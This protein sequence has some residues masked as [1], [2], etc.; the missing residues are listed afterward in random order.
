MPKNQFLLL[1]IFQNTE[2]AQLC[3]IADKKA[4]TKVTQSLHCTAELAHL[5]K[6]AS[7]L[8]LRAED[9]DRA[10]YF[11]YFFICSIIKNDF[12]AFCC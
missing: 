8:V 5:K 1:K 4:T 6:S 7:R 2:S 3:Q 11:R 9:M 10:G 12:L